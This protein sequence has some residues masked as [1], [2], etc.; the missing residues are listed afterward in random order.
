LFNDNQKLSPPLSREHYPVKRSKSVGRTASG[1][2]SPNETTAHESKLSFKGSTVSKANNVRNATE[3]TGSTKSERSKS[4]HRVNW[5][6]PQTVPSVD[7]C[8]IE[9]KY[10]EIRC[11][12][13]RSGDKF[14]KFLITIPLHSFVGQLFINVGGRKGLSMRI[15]ENVTPGETVVLIAPKSLRHSLG[16][17]SETSMTDECTERSVYSDNV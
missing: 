7:T 13:Y 6:S 4:A 8:A 17:I 11:E 12:E 5:H 10:K 3:S 15:P 1:R 9:V 2:H 16:K 14:D